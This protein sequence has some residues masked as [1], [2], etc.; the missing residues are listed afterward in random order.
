MTTTEM[1]AEQQTTEADV[2]TDIV[3]A[4]GISTET[5]YEVTTDVA[6]DAS[7]VSAHPTTD[8]AFEAE[9]STASAPS[10]VDI[11]LETEVNTETAHST[12]D[13]TTEAFTELMTEV[14]ITTQG[15]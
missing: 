10:T 3:Q 12:A 6:V 1:P 4:E 13:I 11:A 15:M 2:S 9:V 7:T 14:E 5:I 8:V